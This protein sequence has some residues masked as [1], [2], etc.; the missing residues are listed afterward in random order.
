AN[1]GPPLGIGWNDSRVKI[2]DIIDGTSNQL[3]F[4]ERCFRMEGLNIGAGNALGFSPATPSAPY[5]GQQC[6]A[7]L[8]VV[9][10]PYWGLNQSVVN[11]N[12]HSRGFASTHVGG[13]HFGLADGSV[14]F[15]SDNIDHKPNTIGVP[16]ATTGGGHGGPTFIDSTLERLMARNDGQPVGEF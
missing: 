16:P 15:I 9:G 14:R 2:R 10:I 8:A 5:T 1:F 4:G 3:V 13:V 11:A 6:R 7:C 12:H